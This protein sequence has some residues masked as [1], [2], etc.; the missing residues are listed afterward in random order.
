MGGGACV[1][2]KKRYICF[3]D[4]KL[5]FTHNQVKKFKEMWSE[6]YACRDIAKL[7]CC[8]TVEIEL[9]AGD[10][11]LKEELEV[12]EGGMVG[13]KV[14]KRNDKIKIEVAI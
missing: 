8:K 1:N 9:L 14:V 11:F 5:D 13:T 10:L 6:G 4:Y 2:I 12:R 7:F 3:E